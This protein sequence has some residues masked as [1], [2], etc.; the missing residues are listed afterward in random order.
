[1]DNLPSKK[2]IFCGEG[3]TTK[4]DVWPTWLTPYV[5]RDIPSYFNSISLI[6]PEAELT[7]MRKKMPGDPR[8]RRAKCVCAKCNNEW[9]SGLQER[10]KPVVLKLAIG[11]ETTLTPHDQ[12]LLTSWATMSTITSEYFSPATVAISQRD[13]EKF[14]KTEQALKNFKIWIGHYQRGDWK[15]H[16]L[17]YAWGKESPLR[18]GAAKPTSQRTT[19]VFGHLFLP[20]GVLPEPKDHQP[21]CLP[22]TTRQ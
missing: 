7:T 1:M 20:C 17:H 4:E 19:L 8:N 5:P 15:P 6:S 22:G 16:Y 13:R 21:T 18:S 2:C 10:A 9:M 12:E 3:Q 11:R 14:W